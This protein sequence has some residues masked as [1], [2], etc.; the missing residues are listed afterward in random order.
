MLSDRLNVVG[1]HRSAHSNITHGAKQTTSHKRAWELTLLTH[2][3]VT[4]PCQLIDI[5]RTT[6][7][8][9]TPHGFQS[10]LLLFLP[11]VSVVVELFPHWFRKPFVYGSVLASIRNAG[12]HSKYYLYHESVPTSTQISLFA[13][14][15]L[16]GRTKDNEKCIKNLFCRYLAKQQDIV[17]SIP[18]MN[19]L[20]DYLTYI[21]P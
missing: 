2:G 11:R 9:V 17:I 6:T 18:F 8:F 1:V 20:T 10:I 19:K 16:V 7:V 3:E 13:N 14:L 21:F 15:A 5:M 4:S 12:Y